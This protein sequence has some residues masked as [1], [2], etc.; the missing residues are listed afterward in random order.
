[1]I[2]PICG[3]TFLPI[4]GGL[5]GIYEHRI[6]NYI[7]KIKRSCYDSAYFPFDTELFLL[8][9]VFHNEQLSRIADGRYRLFY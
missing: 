6:K 2:T 5:V 7:P 3:N 4:Q 8:I 1:M 9:H